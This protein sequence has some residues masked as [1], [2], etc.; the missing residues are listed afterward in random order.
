MLSEGSHVTEDRQAD[1]EE[2][3]KLLDADQRKQNDE[4]AKKKNFQRMWQTKIA[5]RG[6]RNLRHVSAEMMQHL[7]I[8]LHQVRIK[9]YLKN[10][11]KSFPHNNSA[12]KSKNL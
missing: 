8:P 4:A 3:E 5:L 12:N 7:P 9:T 11:H 10:G 2:H 1:E 6:R